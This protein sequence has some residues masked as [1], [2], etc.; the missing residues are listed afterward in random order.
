MDQ[1]QEKEILW[2][3]SFV[4]LLIAN[5]FTAVGFQILL[6][7]LPMFVSLHEGNSSD[8]GLVIGVLTIAAV[9]IRPFSGAASDTLGRKIILAIGVFICF[10]AMV[11][12]FWASTIPSILFVRIV[13]G[14]GWGIATSA[15]GTLASDMVPASR[16]GE[17]I[18]YFGF[19]S[20][21]A[22]ALGPFIGIGLMNQ[23]DFTAVLG[24]SAVS[25]FLS[26]T[27]L[28]LIKLPKFEGFHSQ[29]SS[30]MARLV[31]SSSL[32][33]SVLMGL[34]GLVYGGI[35]SFITLF[36]TEVGIQNVGWFFL[37]NAISS[38]LIRP[39][40]GRLFD[41]KGH[42]YVL[43]PGA[44]L[45]LT[46]VLLLSYATSTLHLSFAAFF[47]G[48]G[49]GAIQPSLQAWVINRAAPSRRGAANATFFSA[50]D[51]GISG[52][53]IMLG[54]VA[55]AFNYAIMYRCSSLILVIFMITYL[56]YIK[57]RRRGGDLSEDCSL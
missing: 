14:I 51:L 41:K 39:L 3:K 10:L 4:F 35:V 17:G 15:F 25:T 44:L 37:I 34:L 16:R 20:L 33:P 19:A 49:M 42:I 27:A 50:F 9:L 43:L 48:F 8:V 52:G 55:R 57:F 1:P 53:A 6:P 36:G 24:F 26:L 40:S 54:G 13:H 46:G 2:T 23:F 56:V 30:I 38:F 5:L 7:T 28:L 45:S 32:F 18:G 22:G 47:F 31:E 21:I 12:Y 29:S 11:F